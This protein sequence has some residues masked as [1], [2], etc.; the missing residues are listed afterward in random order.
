MSHTWILD[1]LADLKAYARRNDLGALAE[2][3]DDT[4]HVAVAELARVAGGP[5]LLELDGTGAGRTDH[6]GRSR[7]A[8]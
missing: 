3:L 7:G 1:V 4:R 2:H 8:M 6:A 5:V